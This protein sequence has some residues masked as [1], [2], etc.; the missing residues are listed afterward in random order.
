[1]RRIVTVSLAGSAIEWY[2]FFIYASASALVFNKLFFPT[3]DASAGTLLAFSTFAVGFL[4]RPIGAAVFGHFGDK[5]GRKSTLVVAM[6]LMG[7]ATTAI[8]LL[9]TY[10]SAGV[11]APVLLVALRLIQGL[12]L[13]GQWGGAVLLATENAPAGKRG[14]YGGFAQ[15]GVPFALIISNVVFLALSSMTSAD[16]F[17]S[18]GWRIPFLLSVVLI[19]VGVYA[20]AAIKE[21]P[22]NSTTR[23]T[24]RSPF[25]TLLRTHPREILL[26]AGTSIVSGAAYYL[27]A[28]Y[29]LAYATTAVGVART[30]ILIA[31]LLSAVA[32]AIMIPVFS[33]LSDRIGRQRAYRIG[34]TLLAVWAF[35]LFWLLNSGSE[36]G[37]IIALVV[38]QV[39]FSLPYSALPA[40][41]SECF[42]SGVRYSGV[43]IGYQI[44]AVLGGAFAPIIATALYSWLHSS[45]PVSL[46][47]IAVCAVSFVAVVLLSRL[48]PERGSPGSVTL[49]ENVR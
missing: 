43:A 40:L 7:A 26:A 18:W 31:V 2:D 16:S 37:M 33:S 25:V 27:L 48:R 35:P 23:E 45:T 38:G 15:L 47:F 8:G 14:F 36:W 12:A 44:G 9:P 10:S 28:V 11:L 3:A 5:F 6:I 34:T 30:Q 49:M 20:Q 21:I 39:I 4:I 17:L 22:G 1:M 41:L 13:G 24:P 19:T 29:A 42:G 32:S 46:Y